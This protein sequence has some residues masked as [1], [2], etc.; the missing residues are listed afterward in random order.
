M[1]IHLFRF[2]SDLI[3]LA[4][5]SVT[6]QAIIPLQD[7][8]GLNTSARMNLSDESVGNWRWC[9]ESAALT[10]ELCDSN[11]T[12]ILHLSFRGCLKIHPTYV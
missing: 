11:L 2:F 9:Y 7:I 5:S 3:Q 8:L 4:H 10:K 12:A 1:V 6:N